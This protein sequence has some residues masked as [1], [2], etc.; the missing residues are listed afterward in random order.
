MNVTNIFHFLPFSPCFHLSFSFHVLNS[1]PND[2]ILDATKLKAFA[3]DRIK[4]EAQMMISVFHRVENIVRKGENDGYQHFLLFSQ[5]FKKD[6]FLGV[7]KGL[8]CVGKS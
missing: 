4:F 1:S 5:C 3:D 8:D 2:K 6:P 7:V